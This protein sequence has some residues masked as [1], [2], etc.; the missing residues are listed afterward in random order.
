MIKKFCR[1]HQW[2]IAIGAPIIFLVIVTSTGALG[3]GNVFLFSVEKNNFIIVGSEVPVTITV[4]SR[5]PV[6]AIGGTVTFPPDLLQVT[7]LSRISSTIDLW[8]EEPTILNSE[9]TVHFSGGI[10]GDKATQPLHGTVIVLTM[11]PLKEGRA[12]LTLKDGQLLAADG[13]GTNIVSGANTLSL[14]IRSGEKPSPD[15]NED[16]VLGLSDVNSLYIKTF[17]AYD[18]RY[19]LNGDGKVSWADVR[20]LM[21]L[22]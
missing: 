21:S 2:K 1:T 12:T 16:G 6:N 7:G 17:R 13:V 11:K 4:D 3:V 5:S 8:S 10:I 15:I 22:F 20:S 19:D 14:Y 18:P 9:G